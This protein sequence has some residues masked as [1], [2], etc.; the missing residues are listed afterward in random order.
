M[1][2]QAT[3][4]KVLPS[5]NILKCLVSVF[6]FVPCLKPLEEKK[7][8]TQNLRVTLEAKFRKQILKWGMGWGKLFTKRLYLESKTVLQSVLIYATV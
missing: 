8:T 3:D 4:A 6:Y 1:G 2:H 7:L 5:A